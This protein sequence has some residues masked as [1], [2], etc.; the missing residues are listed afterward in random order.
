[1]R[2]R[3]WSELSAAQ[4]VSLVVATA[5]QLSLAA[6]AWRDLA[7]R[8]AE[9]VNGSK[10]VWGAVIAVNFIGPVLYL[11]RGRSTGQ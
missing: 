4:R 2:S 11:A 8:P 10:R 3:R 7:R 9:L 1:M 5:V 6:W